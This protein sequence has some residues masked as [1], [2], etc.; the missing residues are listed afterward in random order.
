MRTDIALICF[1]FLFSATSLLAEWEAIPEASPSVLTN[2]A[3][4]WGFTVS[5]KGQN[6]TLLKYLDGAGTLDLSNVEKDTGYKVTGVGDSTFS[7]N[8][9]L[10]QLIVPDVVTTGFSSFLNCKS[11]T[12]ITLSSALQTIG[13]SCFSRCSNLKSFSP[14]NM[15]NLTAFGMYGFQSCSALNVDMR[16]P[17]ITSIPGQSFI[18]AGITS[19][20]APMVT[21]VE[22]GAFQTASKLTNVVI[23]STSTIEIGAFL[24]IGSGANIYWLGKKAP[25]SI[26]KNSLSASDN[27]RLC[28]YVRNGKDIE[29]WKGYCVELR[30]D[31]S[32][33]AYLTAADCPDN[34]ENPEP[35]VGI[36]GIADGGV[37]AWLAHWSL[38]NPTL[39]TIR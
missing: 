5:A 36:L 31:E 13:R 28:V 15:T 23:N 11:V 14:L 38:D 25:T 33:S 12:N 4:G 32:F 16:M 37:N 29:N 9:S 3:T 24:K 2:G 34:R 18:S 8:A 21:K 19:L 20:Y 6:L 1:S 35:V 22:G 17:L 39:L 30:G 26:K 7:G 27:N 10:T